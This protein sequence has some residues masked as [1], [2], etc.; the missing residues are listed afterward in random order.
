MWLPT[1]ALATVFLGVLWLASGGWRGW[2]PSGDANKQTDRYAN[3][4][5]SE[6]NGLAFVGMCLFAAA[7]LVLGFWTL[8]S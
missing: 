2:D 5:G 4:L 3:D 7:T 8:F 6:M 1:C